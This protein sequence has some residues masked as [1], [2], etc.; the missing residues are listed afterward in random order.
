[1]YTM[2]SAGS[3]AETKSD[4]ASK[5]QELKPDMLVKVMTIRKDTWEIVGE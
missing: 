4:V 1:M 2:S 3:L 5:S